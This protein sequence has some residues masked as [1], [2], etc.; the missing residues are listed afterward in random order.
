MNF[1]LKKLKGERVASGIT[2]MEAAIT[3]GIS[4]TSYWKRKNG[5]VPIGADELA[6]LSNL[7]GES[8]IRVFLALMFPIVNKIIRIVTT[9]KKRK[10]N[11]RRDVL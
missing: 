3:L 4:R 10:I 1:N 11:G 8:D 2:Q 9:L 7:F 6:K 5:Y